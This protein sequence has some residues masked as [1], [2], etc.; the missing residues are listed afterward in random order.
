MTAETD[1]RGVPAR[2]KIYHITHLRNLGGITSAGVWSDAKRI[3]LTLDSQVIGMHSIKRRRLDHLGVSCHPGT[4]VGEYVP[5]YFCPRSVMLYILHMGNHPELEYREGQRPIVHLR[6]DL[7]ETVDWADSVGVRWAFTDR[8]AGAS[9]TAFYDSLADLGRV[10]WKAVTS[11]DFRD[12]VVKDGKQAE[13]L[14]H[15]FFPW[16]LIDRIGVLDQ[17]VAREV[18]S[19]LADVEHRP[20]VTLEPR[21]YY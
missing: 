12:P 10:D 16:S 13:F 3:E 8:N 19:L 4:R 21:W 5:F 18:D 6:A 14:V 7:R 11:T 2:P 15:E 20:P 17:G 1:A 9:Y